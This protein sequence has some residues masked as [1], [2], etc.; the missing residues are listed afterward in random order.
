MLAFRK[1]KL[2]F[3]SRDIALTRKLFLIAIFLTAQFI[4]FT[5]APFRV[6]AIEITGNNHLRD[7]AVLAQAGLRL[8]EPIFS[9]P[10]RA[11]EARVR[12]LHWVDDV[13]VRRFVPGRIQ[14]RI[15][16]RVPVLAVANDSQAGPFPR[17][18]FLVS[19]DGVILCA[20]DAN[21]DKGLPR[22]LLRQ[23]L[24]VGH[25]VRARLVS[26]IRDV[27][28]ALPPSLAH[29]VSRLRADA[30]GQVYL[31]IGLLGRSVEVR[32]GGAD[33][34]TYKFEVLQALAERLRTEGKPVAYIDLRYNDPAVGRVVD[35]SH[36]ENLVELQQ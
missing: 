32:L 22:I 10:L 13:A 14:I 31:N 25:K 19:S 34:S 33:R 17:N 11:V 7:D 1:S 9:V 20:A 8:H 27:L 36:A 21:G 30:E 5:S 18:W 3:R 4:F 6:Q 16:E 23:P 28:A 26:N 24:S 2:A 35:A 15:R 29:H 12:A